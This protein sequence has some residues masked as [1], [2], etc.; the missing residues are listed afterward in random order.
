MFDRMEEVIS[1][2]GL[3]M[4]GCL[5]AT[6]I[7]FNFNW[8]INFGGVE[9]DFQTAFLDALLPGLLPLVILFTCFGLLNKKVT[10]TKLIYGI[11]VVCIIFAYLGIV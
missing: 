2:A 6:T 11:L 5:T 8:V 7:R 9:T 3:M 1:I 4:M 10:P